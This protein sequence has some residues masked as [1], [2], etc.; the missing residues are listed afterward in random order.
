MLHSKEFLLVEQQFPRISV[1]IEHTWGSK[2]CYD[3]LNGLLFDTRDNTRNGF[4]KDVCCAIAK[5]QMQHNVEFPQFSGSDDVW[6]SN[7]FK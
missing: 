4:S 5:L 1:K 2:E 7:Y 6:G 3:Y